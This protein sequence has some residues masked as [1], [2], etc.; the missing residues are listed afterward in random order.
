MS[1]KQNRNQ[2]QK[3]NC[4]QA[5]K[6][7]YGDIQSNADNYTIEDDDAIAVEENMVLARRIRYKDEINFTQQ[8]IYMLAIEAM[9]H[10]VRLI[11]K[12]LIRRKYKLTILEEQ[13]FILLTHDIGL[14]VFNKASQTRFDEC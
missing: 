6:D 9:I 3:T 8:D 11:K 14:T 13:A 1:I 7:R 12:A 4:F 5:N 10:L 2:I